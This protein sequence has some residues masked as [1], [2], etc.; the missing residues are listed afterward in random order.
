MIAIINLG[1]ANIQSVLN[2]LDYLSV[3]YVLTNISSEIISADKII[4]PGVGSFGNGVKQLEKFEIYETLRNELMFNNKPVLGVCLGMQLLF[5][6]SEESKGVKGL[7]VLK[8][9]VVELPI[10][11]NYHIPRI[12]WDDSF[13]KKDFLG[14]S[15]GSIYDFYYLHSYYVKPENKEIVTITTEYNL[16]SAVEKE[17]IFGCQFHPEKSHVVVMKIIN[18]F[19]SLRP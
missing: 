4:L 9:E 6:K 14:L 17:N 5:E 13:V 1:G 11:N 16:T 12:G 2:V 7:G 10:S 15:N 18:S 3:E 8:G 19:C